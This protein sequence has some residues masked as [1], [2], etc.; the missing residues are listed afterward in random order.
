MNDIK[1]LQTTADVIEVL[2]RENVETL[3]ASSPQTVSNWKSFGWFPPNTYVVMTAALAL[4]GRSAP[5]S[6]WKMRN[7][8]VAAE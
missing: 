1:P 3:T 4:K 5:A 2:G 6:L 7:P 8:A